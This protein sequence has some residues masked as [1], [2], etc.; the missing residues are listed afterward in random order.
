MKKLLASALLIAILLCMFSCQVPEDEVLTD[1]D[2]TIKLEDDEF[3]L[4]D[5][6]AL[7]CPAFLRSNDNI[8][9]ALNYLQAAL[10]ACGSKGYVCNDSAQHNRKG[11][12]IVGATS[13]PQSEQLLA[14]MGIDGFE[15][16][17]NSQSEIVI[18]GGSNAST[19][20]AV[21]EFCSRVLGYDESKPD[22]YLRPIL[23]AIGF[24]KQAAYRDEHE[25][26]IGGVALKDFKIAVSRPRDTIYADA[27]IEALGVYTGYAFPTVLFEELTPDDKGVICVGYYDRAATEVLLNGADGYSVRF[28]EDDGKVTVGIGATVRQ[29]YEL[30]IAALAEVLGKLQNGQSLEMPA[31]P[32]SNISYYTDPTYTPEWFLKSEKSE[33][34]SDGVEYKEFLYADAMGK[35]YRAYALIIDPQKNSLLMGSANDGY[36][37]TT[38]SPETVADQMLAAQNN[39]Y[40]VIAGVNADFF[41]MGGDNHP[42]GLTVK[43]GVLISKGSAGRA[44]FA[45]TKD[46]KVEIGADGASADV[47]NLQTAVG[48]SDIL[49]DNYIP[50]TFDMVNND[51]NYTAHPRTLAGVREDGSIILAI[52][53][54]RQDNISNG[55]SLE[56][57][58]LLMLS[59]GAKNAVNLDGGGSTCLITNRGGELIT[60]NSPSDGSLRKVYNSLIVYKKEN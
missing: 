40:N 3:L 27:I 48:G 44:Y 5:E 12:I 7:V 57:C 2:V 50:R 54:G 60:H 49:V 18:C 34:V 45:I 51:F 15:Y 10:L 16:F 33:I 47:T 37:Y 13:R 1:T 14:G 21:K 55:A 4:L 30:A 26:Y 42:T 32:I 29:Q 53:D 31:E 41:A 9:K 38:D 28:S 58:A 22:A 56:R 19:F 11:E 6:Y 24:S 8:V 43:Q 52:I 36:E 46:G 59:L 23:K 35:P 39:G 25:I 17:V 20:E